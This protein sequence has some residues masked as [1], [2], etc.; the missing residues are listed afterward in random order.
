MYRVLVIAHWIL[1][2]AHGLSS[3][4]E[5]CGILVPR[6]GIKLLSPA[7]E[8]RFLTTSPPGKSL[9]LLLAHT[10]E[11]LWRKGSTSLADLVEYWENQLTDQAPLNQPISSLPD[12]SI[13]LAAWT[14]GPRA[15]E[16]SFIVDNDLDH[17]AHP[18]RQKGDPDH[19]CWWFQCCGVVCILPLLTIYT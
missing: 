8:G 10:L 9:N 4:P 18:L 14:S 3:S 6:P 5:A 19:P 13:Q 1:I 11:I 17:Q 12:F 7:L 15:T 2:V 16:G